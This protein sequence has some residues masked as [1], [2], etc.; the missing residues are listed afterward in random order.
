MKFVHRSVELR[1][2]MQIDE[3][4]VSDD[5][6]RDSSKFNASYSRSFFG[7]ETNLFFG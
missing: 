6:D 2:V 1:H 7:I 5:C 4:Q 3:L